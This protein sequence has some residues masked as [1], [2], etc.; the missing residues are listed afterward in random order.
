MDD[1]AVVTKG[2]VRDFVAFICD[3][4]ARRDGKRVGPV[5]PLFSRGFGGVSATGFD[6]ANP[7][8]L[9]VFFEAVGEV[10]GLGDASKLSV[11]FEIELPYSYVFLDA[12]IDRERVLVHHGENGIQ[13]HVCPLFWDVDGEDFLNADG[14]GE[15]AADGLYR[16]GRAALADADGDAVFAE[17]Q[18]IPAFDDV[19]AA[20]FDFAAENDLNTLEKRV[21]LENVLRE[22]GFA[23]SG[24]EAH[25]AQN[26][27]VSDEEG[28]I[29]L[30]IKIWQGAQEKRRV[31]G[32][33]E[34]EALDGAEK[35]ALPVME[36][37]P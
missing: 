21:V 19:R 27:A 6:A 3:H 8:D 12:W 29:S 25:G 10:P 2:F 11:F 26:S 7:V 5:V 35:R 37:F 14:G 23:L 16:S 20:V 9:K 1:D 17:D 13:V 31:T 24:K 32:R 4:D 15:S 22:E 36:S 34:C 28:R 18:K 30:K 33:R